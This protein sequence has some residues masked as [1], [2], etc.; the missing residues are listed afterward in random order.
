MNNCENI[1]KFMDPLSIKSLPIFSRIEIHIV[2]DN[3]VLFIAISNSSE[4]YVGSGI[5]S[6]S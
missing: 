2:S 4:L 1:C 3:K 5:T 6:K